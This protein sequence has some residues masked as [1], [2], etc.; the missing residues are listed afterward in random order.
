MMAESELPTHAM[1]V[2]NG[3]WDARVHLFRAGDEVDTFALVTQQYLIVI[4]TMTT[5]EMARDIM[6][7]LQRI[8]QGRHL[9][10]INTH[11]HYDHCWGNAIFADIESRYAAPIIGHAKTREILLSQAAKDDLADKQAQQPRLAQVKLAPPTLTFTDTFQID[12][13]DLALELLPTPGHTEDHIAVWIPRIA[14]LLA[15]DAAEFPFPHVTRAEDLP[16]LRAS[17]AKMQALGPQMVLPCHGGTTEP[18]LL[19]R[20][21]SYFDEV[22]R[23]CQAA[24]AA[25]TVP[26]DWATNE[27]LPDLIGFP[28][29]EALRFVDADP[30]KTPKFYQRF[31]LDAL[32]VTLTAHGA[33]TV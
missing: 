30:G 22:A 20:N 3:G 12:G 15:G 21:L 11:A 25:G 9:L 33:T 32:R 14:L 8:R 17:L 19:A 6:Q 1:L 5:P 2:H 26:E 16:V 10:V 13:G 24:Q 27:Q 7:S 23:R 18:T 31:H 29:L 28:Y 4:D